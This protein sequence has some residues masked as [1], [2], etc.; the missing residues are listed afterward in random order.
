LVF[1][2]ERP[3]RIDGFPNAAGPFAEFLHELGVRSCA[4]SPIVVEGLTWGLLVVA[5]LQSEPLPPGT[6]HRLGEF[7]DLVATAISNAETRAELRASRA[8]IV[9]AGDETRRGIE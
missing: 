5:S 2:T 7:T 9:A 6:E 4:G 3:A 1:R 8:R